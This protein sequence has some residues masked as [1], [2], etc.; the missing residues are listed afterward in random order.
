MHEATAM[1]LTSLRSIFRPELAL[2]APP[3]GVGR[4]PTAREP[5]QQ[6]AAL[7]AASRDGAWGEALAE[8]WA[9]ARQTWP[10]I[11]LER[12]RFARHCEVVLGDVPSSAWA[13]Q[14]VELYLCCACVAG[15]ATAQRV[16]SLQYLRRVE[17]QLSLSCNDA[18]LVDEAMQA[19]RIKLLVGPRPKI[20]RFAARGPLLHWLRVAAKRTLLDV[21]RARRSQRLAQQE[22]SCEPGWCEADPLAN[23]RA[24]RY[25]Q[26]FLDGLQHTIDGLSLQDRL[27]M[28]HA[29]VEGGTIDVIGSLYA[30]HRSTVARRL[31]RIRRGLA[32]AVRQRLKAEHRLGDDDI[33]ELTRELCHSLQPSLHELLGGS[34]GE[35][36]GQ[37]E[38]PQREQPPA[39]QGAAAAVP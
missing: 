14:G 17:Q 16:L 25:A 34:A 27:L 28:Q 8:V 26:T 18:E 2:V 15:N 12:E 4:A 37:R 10:N 39:Q 13:E 21:A 5:E 1:T 7:G 11:T 36:P 29:V 23:I 31:Q 19:L 6:R 30:I 9:R 20:A 35:Q 24:A 38:Q 33:D 32:V 22:T 3:G